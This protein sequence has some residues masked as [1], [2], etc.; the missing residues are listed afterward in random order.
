LGAALFALLPLEAG[1]SEG[2]LGRVIQGVAAG[3]GFLG[4]GAILKR[5]DAGEI[6]G[7]TTAASIWLTAALGLAVGVGRLWLP[8]VCAVLAWLILHVLSLTEARARRHE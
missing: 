4:A 1:G 6:S 5:P 3:I 8:I 2:D 7:L